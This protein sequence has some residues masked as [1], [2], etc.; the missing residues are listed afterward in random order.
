MAHT[1]KIVLRIHRRK[2]ERQIEDVF[3]KG[4]FGFGRGRELVM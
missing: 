2:T 4:H 1:A 3:E